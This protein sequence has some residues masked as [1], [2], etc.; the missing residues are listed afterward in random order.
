MADDARAQTRI[1]SSS[2]VTV[3]QRPS[4][5][6]LKI[7]LHAAE[8]TLELGLARLKKQC[9]A[10]SRWLKRLEAVRVEF[11]EPHF[12]GRND[13][14]PLQPMRAAAARALGQRP[15]QNPPGDRPRELL[16]VLTA[17]WRI[18]EMSAEETLVFMDR[19]QFEAADGEAAEPA[20]EPQ[21]W[22]SPQEQLHEILAR[23]GQP[24]AADRAPQF[25]FISEL[26]EEQWAK[27]FEEA[28]TQ[29]RLKAERQARALGRRLGRLG[30]VSQG[31][32][33]VD[34]ARTDLVMR[35]QRC[36]GL[37]A[38]ASYSLSG[39][40]IVSDDPRCVDFAVK[41]DAHYALED[42]DGARA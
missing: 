1:T 42:G 34:G 9:E 17:M 23:M 3:R 6:L 31:V 30:H 21:P 33:L 37:L 12:A 35:R 38:G 32:N 18:S 29:A 2:T 8:A 13:A 20:D 26:G 24:S 25:L 39:N 41:V 10:A 22:A 7:P 40:D 11:G 28:F 4:W 5:L 27:A 16:V 15:A 36:M 14:D 19:L